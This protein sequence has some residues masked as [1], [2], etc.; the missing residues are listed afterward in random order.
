MKV[1]E[2]NSTVLFILGIVLSAAIFAADILTPLGIAWGF[3]YI[4]VVLITLWIPGRKSTLIF[5]VAGIFLT[6]LKFY[7]SSSDV[8]AIEIVITNRLLST[9]GILVTMFGILKYKEKE[10]LVYEQNKEVE[11]LSEELKISNGDLEQ[12]AYVASHDLQEPLRKI[13]SFGDR[14]LSGEKEKLS[15]QGKDYFSRMMNAS[16][17]MQTLIN[18]LL[19]FSRLNTKTESFAK[20]DLNK[21]LKEVVSDLE[22]TIEKTQTII[23]AG[24]LPVI[25]C[26]STQIRQLFQNLISNGIKFRKDDKSP[27]IKIYSRNA[28]KPSS[29]EKEFSEIYFEDDGIGFDEKYSDKIFNIFQRLEGKKYEG[30]GIGL[31]VCKKIALRHG[32]DI[33]VKSKLGEGTTF[34]VS[35]P[36]NPIS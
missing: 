12:F 15:E 27:L 13:Q 19:A 32:G 11:K 1:K 28:K 7:V 16:E 26:R 33:S 3:L 23:D 9:F 10:R 24:N 30:S 14:I 29:P 20:V 25:N 4:I 35:L 18:D 34:I 31:A 5:T 17:R 36:L 21:L 2:T 8:V 6:A 22:V